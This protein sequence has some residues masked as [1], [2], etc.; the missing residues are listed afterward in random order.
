[1]NSPNTATASTWDLKEF[2][3]VKQKQ[4]KQAVEDKAIIILS[5]FKNF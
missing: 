3:S 5:P 4:T 2:Q 1:M